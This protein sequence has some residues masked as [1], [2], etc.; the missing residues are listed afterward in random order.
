M[1]GKLATVRVK[2]LTGT[3]PAALE[4][5][6]ETWRA[7]LAEER[8]VQADFHQGDGNIGQVYTLCVLYTE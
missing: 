1:Q 2:V 4:T 3:T 8:L 5:A 7:T 6:F